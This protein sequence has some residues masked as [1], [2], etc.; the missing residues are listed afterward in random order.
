MARHEVPSSGSGKSTEPALSAADLV[1]LL[2]DDARLRCV[3]AVVL[4]ASTAAEVADRTGLATRYV[5]R[6]LER[7]AGAGLVER[8]PA[9]LAVGPERFQEAAR[10]AAA[11]RPEVNP[12]DLGAT[13]EQAAVLR[14][15]VGAEGRLV[16]I[17]TSRAKR[18]VVL[19]F[20]AGRFE[21]GKVYPELDVNGLLGQV[22]DD[23]AALRRY[24][25]DEG[26]LER[27]DGFYWRSGGTYN[28]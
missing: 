20:L 5:V 22:H 12:E 16:S 27:R 17:P 10:A 24:L 28:V 23:Y 25:V 1:G 19:D 11:S 14:N 21:P 15:F 26:F 4:G 8:G 6:A 18:R 9:G 13:P 7:L 2:A 3:A